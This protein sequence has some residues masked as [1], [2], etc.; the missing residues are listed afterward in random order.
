MPQRFLRPGITNSERF[1]TVSLHAQ[2]LWLRILTRVDDFGRYD[3]RASVLAGELFSVWNELHPD[4]VVNPLRIPALRSELQRAGLANF[5]TSEGKEI[6]QL[7]QWEERARADKS[8]WPDPQ[9]SAAER[10]GTQRNPASLASTSSPSPP[11][12]PQLSPHFGGEVVVGNSEPVSELA[13]A[14]FIAQWNGL[15]GVSKCRQAAGKRA[16]AFKARMADQFFRDNWKAAL[17][18]VAQSEF[19]KGNGDRGWH[20]DID[21]IL[22]PDTCAK[23]ME[24][25]YDNRIQPPELR[26]KL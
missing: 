7:L 5:Y 1:N 16:K 23:I 10:S 15:E 17:A 2:S 12:P 3:A 13:L 14:E 6:V 19:C 8:K 24:G 21:W 18:K 26:F 11:P 22:R 20:A 25:K 4:D 9:E